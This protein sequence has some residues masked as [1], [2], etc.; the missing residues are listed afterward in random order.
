MRQHIAEASS[1]ETNLWCLLRNL[2]NFLQD[3]FTGLN[4]AFLADKLFALGTQIQTRVKQLD[5]ADFHNHV[6][7]RAL[8]DGF[9]EIAFDANGQVFNLRGVERGDDER[10]H[11]EHVVARSAPLDGRR[12]AR[13]LA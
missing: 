1:I 3:A 10:G 9:F 13:R 12:A 8:D 11:G 5:H 7:V 4:G 2:D 6:R